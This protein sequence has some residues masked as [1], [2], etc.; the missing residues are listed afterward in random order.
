MNKET[1]KRIISSIVI[2]PIALFFIIKG[3]FF[4][5]F[6]MSV[7]FLV[8][9]YEWYQMSKKHLHFMAIFSPYIH[10]SPNLTQHSQIKTPD[11]NHG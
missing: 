10:I 7:F 9:S 5:I 1:I 11:K 2:I 4:F 3:S 6:F 8:T